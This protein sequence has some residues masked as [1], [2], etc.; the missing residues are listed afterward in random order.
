LRWKR[1]DL[2]RPYRCTGYPWLPGIYILL[3]AWWTL[4]TIWTRPKEAM[5]GTLIV[6][7]GVPFYLFWKRTSR[8]E[9]TN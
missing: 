7:I 4:N 9:S 8:T 5:A 2:P 3:G 6:L 1:P